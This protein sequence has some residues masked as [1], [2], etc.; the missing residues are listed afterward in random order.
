MNT[1]KVTLLIKVVY[2]IIVD[3]HKNEPSYGKN[4]LKHQQK[5]S[6]GVEL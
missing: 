6:A 3:D 5:L 1:I 4:L 2:M